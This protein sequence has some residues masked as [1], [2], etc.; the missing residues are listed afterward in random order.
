MESALVPLSPYSRCPLLICIGKPRDAPVVR[1][2]RVEVG[3]LVNIGITFDHRH[4]DGAH[5]GLMLRRFKKIFDRP[6]AFPKV[7]AP[8]EAT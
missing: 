1:D 6:E 2:G 4:A 5:C 7:F 3:R 8:A